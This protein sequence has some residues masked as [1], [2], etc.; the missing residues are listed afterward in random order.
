MSLNDTGDRTNFESG[1]VREVLDTNGRCDLMPLGII[2]KLFERDHPATF[3]ILK[4]LD[5]YIYT[6]NQ[7]CLYDAINEFI[8]N[9]K[10]S[11]I[12]DLS[13]HY[14]EA[15][16]KYPERN[17]EK[18]LPSHSFIDSG[19]RHLMKCLRGDDDEPHDRAFL[20][21][22]LGLLWN[23]EHHPELVDLPFVDKLTVPNRYVKGDKDCIGCDEQAFSS[24]LAYR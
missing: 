22:M 20:W 23:D 4:A 8:F 9:D 24:V 2:A 6:G 19:V 16:A 1:A 7:N 18:G 21:N 3:H 13:K 11:C 5:V 10:P 14:K 15:L 12:L 17:W